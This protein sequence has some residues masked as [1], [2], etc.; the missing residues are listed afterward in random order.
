MFE[1]GGKKMQTFEI[2]LA[3]M[4]WHGGKRGV[5]LEFEGSECETIY[6]KNIKFQPGDVTYDETKI[7]PVILEKKKVTRFFEF[8]DQNVDYNKL[9]FLIKQEGENGWEVS[10]DLPNGSVPAIKKSRCKVL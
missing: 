8:P 5:T 3:R 7:F 1:E 10:V 6:I 2:C 4:D 9:T